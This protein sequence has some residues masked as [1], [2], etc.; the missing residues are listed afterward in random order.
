MKN[1]HP[2]LLGNVLRERFSIASAGTSRRVV[3][4][5][6]SASGMLFSNMRPASF[7][8]AGSEWLMYVLRTLVPLVMQ[9]KTGS[10]GAAPCAKSGGA[11]SAAQKRAEAIDNRRRTIV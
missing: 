7:H 3:P 11:T 2:L 1:S 4:S 6:Y 9:P 8:R 5:G 10:F